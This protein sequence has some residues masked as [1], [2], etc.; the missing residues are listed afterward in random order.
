MTSNKN[1]QSDLDALHL[2][3]DTYG[4]DQSRWP[5]GAATQFASLLQGD[6]R[7]RKALTEARALDALLD[8]A[9]TVG[10]AGAA[11]LTDRIMRQVTASADRSSARTGENVVPIPTRRLP[12][13][14]QTGVIRGRWQTAAVLAASLLAGVFAGGTGM[15][16][17]VLDDVAAFA[18]LISDGDTLTAALGQAVQLPLD[19]DT[20]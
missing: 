8:R 18:G 17:S 3:L 10:Q 20:L 4:A 2:V 15:L 13:R 7:A 14:P 16:G 9:P 1:A 19:E 12:A 11:A 6:D 5:D